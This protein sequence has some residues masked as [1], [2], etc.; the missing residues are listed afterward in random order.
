MT[1][2]NF[3]FYCLL[4]FKLKTSMRSIWFQQQHYKGLSPRVFKSRF[5]L[6]EQQLQLTLKYILQHVQGKSCLQVLLFL[7]CLKFGKLSMS[8]E[9][10]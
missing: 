10:K 5:T 4:K 7:W 9:K 6:T 2:E 1:F 3:Y 8:K